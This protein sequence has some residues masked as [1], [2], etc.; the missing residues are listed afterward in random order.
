MKNRFVHPYWTVATLQ[1]FLLGIEQ[2]RLTG[3][4]IRIKTGPQQETEFD[5]K[6][7]DLNLVHDEIVARLAELE[8]A[9]YKDPAA[10]RCT[11]TRSVFY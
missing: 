11:L 7:V 4:A 9:T 10:Q 2:A 5:P 6:S 8:P 1:E 3:K